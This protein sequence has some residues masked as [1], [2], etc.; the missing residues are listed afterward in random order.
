MNSK[1]MVWKKFWKLLL[2]E[3]FSVKRPKN[4]TILYFKCVCDCWNKKDIRA[5]SIRKWLTVSCW[6]KRN[7]RHWLSKTRFYHIWQW[8]NQRCY[9]EKH[10]AYYRYNWKWII[11]EWK[12]FIE[13][14]DDM[15]EKYKEHVKNFWEINTTIDREDNDGNYNKNNCRW[16]TRKE[17]ANNTRKTIPC[18]IKENST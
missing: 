14:K 5:D 11:I 15:L 2:I 3:F 4:W 12:S 18:Y 6:C 16:A 8:M 7:T 1:E 17:Q 13:F 10:E 9:N